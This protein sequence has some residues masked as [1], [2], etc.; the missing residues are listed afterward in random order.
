M[1]SLFFILLLALC[2]SCNKDQAG[3]ISNFENL[4]CSLFEKRDIETL[5]D[6]LNPILSQNLPTVTSTD[7]FGQLL[8]INQFV[9]DL[10]TTCP[11]IVFALACYGC[12]ETFPVQSEIL[13]SFPD[14]TSTVLD[15]VTHDDRG[16]EVLRFHD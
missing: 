2:S 13:I 6:F 15:V 5:K 16:L 3:K 7:D 14:S 11:D 8:H 10:N 4:D 9:T 12:I 1:R